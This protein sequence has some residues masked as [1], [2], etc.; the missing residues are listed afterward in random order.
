[1]RNSLHAGKRIIF[2]INGHANIAF[3]DNSNNVKEL[4]VTM[5]RNQPMGNGTLVSEGDTGIC[6]YRSI[7]NCLFPVKAV[8]EIG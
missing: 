6:V 3:L 7:S 2:L 5:H 8:F 1:M 4:H